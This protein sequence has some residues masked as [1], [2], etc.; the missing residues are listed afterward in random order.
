MTE[1]VSAAGSSSSTSPVVAAIARGVVGVHA[2]YYGRG[3]TKAKAIWKN[4]VVVVI[5]EEIFTKAEETLVGAGHFD[6]VRSHRQT[7]QDEVEGLFREVVE[8]AT[9]R[10]VR[11]FLSQ[12]SIGG[13][14]SEVF[15]LAAEDAVAG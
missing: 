2:R 3:P 10:K 7:F 8:E 11:A 14:A 1:D 13:V 6:Q 4:D 15:V 9:G 5:L 12:V